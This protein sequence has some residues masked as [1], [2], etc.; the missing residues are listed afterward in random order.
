MKT[1]KTNSTKQLQW[2][3]FPKKQNKRKKRTEME[4]FKANTGEDFY[5]TE[6]ILLIKTEKSEKKEEIIINVLLCKWQSIDDDAL[7]IDASV[8]CSITPQQNRCN[9][10]A[11][12]N[13]ITNYQLNKRI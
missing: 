4:I 7:A 9:E 2:K 8:W 5:N 1:K 3:F 6:K 11:S 12:E 10:S 13:N